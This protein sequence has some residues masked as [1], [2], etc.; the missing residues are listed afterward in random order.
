[1]LFLTTTSETLSLVTTGTVDWA[2]TWVDM[3]DAG[4]LAGSDQGSSS[5]TFTI[6]AS[7]A[8]AT[9][10]QVKVISVVSTGGTITAQVKKGTVVLTSTVTLQD[11]YRLSYLDTVGWQVFKAD[12]S[13]LGSGGGGGSVSPLTTKGDLYTYS[14]A[15]ARLPVGTNGQVL[16]ADS[17]ASTG[18]VWAA[19]P[20][21]KQTPTYI[22][23]GETFTVQ[24]NSQVLYV[25]NIAVDG[26]LVLDGDLINVAST[27]AFAGG[28]DTQLQYN[29]GTAFGGTNGL[30]WNNSTPS[31][32][33]FGSTIKQATDSITYNPS[34]IWSL[35]NT[36][37]AN[38]FD[39]I[40]EGATYTDN[41]R[42]GG[43]LTL[44]G[45]SSPGVGAAFLVAGKG[46]Y[47]TNGAACT[48]SGGDAQGSGT[49]GTLYLQSGRNDYGV[50]GT[51]ELYGNE[52]KIKTG[53]GF[54]YTI[55]TQYGSYNLFDPLTITY[56]TGTSGQVLTSRG[57]TLTPLWTDPSGVTSFN[58]RTG[59]VTLSSTDITTALG[60]TP[61]SVAGSTT[62]I[63]YNLAGVSAASAAL[64]FVDTPGSS[65][66]DL[67]LGSGGYTSTLTFNAAT[68]LTAYP[69]GSIRLQSSRALDFLGGTGVMDT[70]AGGQ[71]YASSGD[72]VYT[73]TGETVPGGS[74]DIA[75][76]D[77]TTA[78]QSTGNVSIST[79]VLPTGIAGGYV[80]GATITAEALTNTSSVMTGG[81]VV[82]DG[83]STSVTPN[84]LT[85]GPDGLK[86]NGAQ[87]VESFN[88]RVGAV[89]LTSGDVTTALGFTPGAVTSVAASVPAFLSVTG[90]PITTSGTLAI[91]L[92]GTALPVANGGTGQTTATAAFDGL[93]PA[94]TGNSG[95]YL[96][97]NGTTTSWGTVSAGTP[98]GSN[99]QVQFN[100]SGAFGGSSS[101]TYASNNLRVGNS[102]TDGSLQL[103]T[104]GTYVAAVG[105]VLRLLTAAAT[106][107][108]TLAGNIEGIAG[109]YV[110]TDTAYGSIFHAEGGTIYGGGNTY[111]NSGDY[112]SGGTTT[113]GGRFFAQG[114]SSSG[115]GSVRISTAGTDRLRI[116]PNGEFQLGSGW[117][118][119]SSG[120]TLTSSG[121]STA[122]TWAYPAPVYTLTT[123]PTPVAGLMITVSNANS[124]AG[125]LCYSD[126]STWKDA[127]THATVA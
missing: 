9:Q 63:Q 15:D 38:R 47:G 89:T 120:Q 83:A 79:G 19:A 90:S 26:S 104:Y 18:L 116:G 42:Q 35:G 29:N 110:G 86:Y 41:N 46:L 85:V 98:A 53:A 127:G 52:V 5:G 33:V 100:S 1:M 55:F 95:K 124:G 118:A 70:R 54:E 28:T 125:A 76:S 108:A 6:V 56:S 32:G 78:Y 115:A 113:Y 88:T 44:G 16:K 109:N 34:V 111:F 40:L 101:L 97:T 25:E 99:T 11:G 22:P 13:V 4:A 68:V 66:A 112:Y 72:T 17:T 3:T 105:R 75:G 96:T 103:G 82:L 20:D 107:G 119:G 91:T 39:L 73:P 58:T 36:T 81:R 23:A 123:L 2:V 93:A 59:A 64:T 48:I 8:A 121:S 61:T 14:S 67:T 122:P 69:S 126:G 21:G 37:T 27:P 49:P 7:P 114:A 24:P 65:T 77:V 117:A 74:I 102:G 57:S 80:S 84:R 106:G 45:D 60:F 51:V 71:F 10:R 62:Q 50:R 31:L 87:L 12:G 30:T 94:Q 92:S 43:R